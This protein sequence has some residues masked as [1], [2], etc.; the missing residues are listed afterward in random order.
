M[1]TPIPDLHAVQPTK[2]HAVKVFEAETVE[3]AANTIASQEVPGVGFVRRIRY[4][5]PKCSKPGTYVHID[6]ARRFAKDLCPECLFAEEIGRDDMVPLLEPED[7]LQTDWTKFKAAWPQI[8][9]VL[10]PTIE[11]A[12]VRSPAGGRFP[13]GAILRPRPAP[14][15]NHTP[16][17][18][19]P[20]ATWR[21]LLARHAAGDHGEF[22]KAPK[23]L[24]DDQKFAPAVFAMNVRNAAAIA[25]GTGLIRSRFLVPASDEDK[26]GTGHF[27]KIIG[28]DVV[29]LA[30]LDI[31][32]SLSAT[33]QPTTAC[34]IGMRDAQCYAGI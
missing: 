17:I 30:R 12:L 16:P 20:D 32:T 9:K 13:L 26:L 22:G 3:A 24:S 6:G 2:P 11:A 5:C 15:F 1:F 10:A 23:T 14:G 21:E 4:H 28:G 34:R 31:V 29:C 7:H 8:S 25:D 27:M 19:I 18:W 33:H